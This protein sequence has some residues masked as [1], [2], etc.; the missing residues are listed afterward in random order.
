MVDF[1]AEMIPYAK[2]KGAQ[3]AITLLPLSEEA[4]ES[5]P[6]D[7]VAAIQGLD[8]FGS[9][10]YW[11]LHQKDYRQY[12]S[13][14]MQ[15]TPQACENNRLTPHFWA[16]GFGVPA[17]REDELEAGINLAVELGAQSVAVWGMH[18]NAAWDGVSEHPEKVWEVVGRTFN[19]LRAVALG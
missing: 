10:P 17:D 9:D 19:Q 14:Q 8:L 3:N 1:L 15:R 13:R 4:S 11:F 2:N 6:W 5:L 7:R 16:Q 12:V 18:G